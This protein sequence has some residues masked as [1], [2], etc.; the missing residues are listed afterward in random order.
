MTKERPVVIRKPEEKYSKYSSGSTGDILVSRRRIVGEIVDPY[1][2]MLTS[3]DISLGINP[4]NKNS[5]NIKG[6]LKSILDK[7]ILINEFVYYCLE[8]LPNLKN[9][10]VKEFFEELKEYIEQN[11]EPL[12]YSYNKEIRLEKIRELIKGSIPNNKISKLLD[13][14]EALVKKTI[15]EIFDGDKEKYKEYRRSVYEKKYEEKEK[16]IQNLLDQKKLSV[17]AIAEKLGFKS[18]P[19]SMYIIRTR[20]Q[21]YFDKCELEK[22]KRYSNEEKEKIFL[23]VLRGM[24]ECESLKK[25]AKNMKPNW[26]TLRVLV[27]EKTEAQFYDDYLNMLKT[28]KKINKKEDNSYK[29]YIKKINVLIEKQELLLKS[30]SSIKKDV[31]KQISIL[32]IANEYGL[33]EE[34]VKKLISIFNGKEFLNKYN[35]DIQKVDYLDNVTE[36]IEPLLEKYLTFTE[37]SK[38]SKHSPGTVSKYVSRTRGI[39]GR[40]LYL[41]EVKNKKIIKLRESQWLKIEDELEAN[42]SITNICKKIKI[43]ERDLKILITKKKGREFLKNYTNK[44]VMNLRESRKDTDNSFETKYGDYIK[45]IVEKNLKDKNIHKIWEILD[46]KLSYLT[47]KKIVNYINQRKI[48]I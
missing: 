30:W 44:I 24:K 25:I 9:F 14:S 22:N 34:Y 47:V 40:K 11:E 43:G 17:H 7:N 45:I 10:V 6:Y 38:L 4:D 35:L 29:E 41:E 19:F 46:K 33:E 48:E 26:I 37:I 31:D 28:V 5:E 27:L 21:E 15:L 18:K 42:L 13:I 2:S 20:G 1:K 39:E 16:E 12:D 32:E 36:D 23:D 8:D 3:F